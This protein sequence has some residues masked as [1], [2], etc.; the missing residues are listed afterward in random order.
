[1]SIFHFKSLAVVTKLQANPFA[2]AAQTSAKILRA[3]VFERV[4]QRFLANVQKVL[5]PGRRQVRNSAFRLKRGVKRGS[6]RYTLNNTLK[7]IPKI[8]FLQC[9]RTQS[10]HRAARFAQTSSSQ[11]AHAL[12]MVVRFLA[13]AA[14]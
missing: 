3:R 4:G 1:M 14:R 7:G 12:Q 5:L 6:D 9:L 8:V 13:P 10:M 11:F 2:I